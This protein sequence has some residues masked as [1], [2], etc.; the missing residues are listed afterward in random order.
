MLPLFGLTGACH[1]CISEKRMSRGRC[2]A[3]FGIRAE[4][5]SRRLPSQMPSKNDD[6]VRLIA[7]E[8]TILDF[9]GNLLGSDDV[10]VGFRREGTVVAR[11]LR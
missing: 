2:L 5:D 11:D 4:M 8:L 7:L 1:E 3:P 10:T 6:A 9:R